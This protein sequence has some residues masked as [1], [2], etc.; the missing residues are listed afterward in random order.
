M[1]HRRSFQEKAVLGAAAFLLAAGVF[2]P[3]ALASP[4]APQSGP[5]DTQQA[6]TKKPQHEVSVVLKLIQVYVTD[7]KGR[8]VDDLALGDFAATDNGQPVV[9]TEFERHALAVVAAGE[10]PSGEEGQP[11]AG[12]VPPDRGTVPAQTR[13]FFLFFDFAFNN[14]R[15]LV[16][17]KTAALHFLDT[18]VSPGDE[19]GVLTYTML[20]G[21]RVHE[22]LTRDI[23][24]I[25]EVV[26]SFGS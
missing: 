12:T 19:I 3:T 8:P 23:A 24:K 22:Y 20:K 25:R 17:A 1:S 7:K 2:G 13:K 16:K 15:G 10:G 9:L 26:E 11:P 4:S 14:A 6:L 21:V 18:K 5:A